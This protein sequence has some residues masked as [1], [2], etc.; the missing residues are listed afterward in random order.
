MISNFFKIN[1]VPQYFV[2]VRQIFNFH[3]PCPTKKRRPLDAIE[4]ACQP[5]KAELRISARVCP[6]PNTKLFYILKY[7]K[8]IT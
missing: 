5:S 3:Q 7:L 8:I 6:N 2:F 1:E 4:Y